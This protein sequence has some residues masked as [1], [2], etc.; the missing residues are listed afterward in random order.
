MV[1]PCAET[2]ITPEQALN[3]PY[4]EHDID[5]CDEIPEE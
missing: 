2:R 1:D 4:F 5:D 3:D